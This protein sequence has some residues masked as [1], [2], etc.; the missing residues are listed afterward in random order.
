[1][2]RIPFGTLNIV[3]VN[4]VELRMNFG[5]VRVKLGWSQGGVR[6]KSGWS[7]DGVRVESGWSKGEAV[8]WSKGE[9]RVKILP[10]NIIVILGTGQI[11]SCSRTSIWYFIIYCLAR[12]KSIFP[13]LFILISRIFPKI[14][15]SKPSA[16]PRVLL[17]HHFTV[18]GPWTKDQGSTDKGWDKNWCL[19]LFPPFM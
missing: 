14:S 18:H 4:S 12:N 15:K 19:F 6:V 5:E 2:N 8:R 17:R 3:R 16:W 1:M 9:T 7:Q 10:F 11:G 13:P